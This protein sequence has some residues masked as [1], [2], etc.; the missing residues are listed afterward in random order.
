MRAL[1]RK[2]HFYLVKRCLNLMRALM[3]W[4]FS[5]DLTPDWNHGLFQYWMLFLVVQELIHSTCMRL[6]VRLL[7]PDTAIGIYFY[8]IYD[9]RLL[10]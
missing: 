2:T 4:G 7:F 1:G 6:T 10:F 9:C 5:K 8:V 3:V